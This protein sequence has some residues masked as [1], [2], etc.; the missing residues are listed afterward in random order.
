MISDLQIINHK[1][2]MRLS[3][4]LRIHPEE[5][6]AFVGGGG[7][8][9]AMFRLADELVTQ[10]K[11]VITTT[12]THLSIA[13]LPSSATKIG[14]GR[15]RTLAPLARG[16]VNADSLEAR[17]IL[18]VGDEVEAGKVVGVP[19]ALIGE[20]IAL[21]VVDAVIYEADGARML[22]FK[23]PAA[24]EPVLSDATTLLVPVIGAGVFGAPLDDAHVHRA[25]IV[26]R[27]AG[28]R[29]GDTVTPIIAA[30]VMAHAGGG[31]KGKPR[32]AH[33]IA[34]VNQVENDAQLDAARTLARLLLGYA[35]IDAVVIG[36]VQNAPNPIRET[37]RRV[38]AI[39]LAAG[40][41]TRMGGRVKQL[42]PWRG[43]TLVENAIAIAAQSSA[44][45]TVIVLGAHAEE[46]RATIR[47]GA[48]RVI[49]NR[50]W[51]TGHASSIRAGLRVLSPQIDAA[52]FVNADQPLL[53]SDVLDALAQRYRETDA[54]IVVPLYAGKRGSPV[55]F[56]RAHFEELANL[57]DEQGGRELLGKYRTK[58]EFVEFAEE[59]L[60]FDVDTAE[61]YESVRNQVF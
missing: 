19:P 30:R 26:A 37:H 35:E 3:Q 38:A 23:A 21:D 34:L 15:A 1:S 22:P 20:L 31:L 28:A 32:T 2:E 27:L 57:R 52:I 56:Q 6:V 53:T 46:I 47:S 45:E 36:A 44:S 8:T 14:C 40:A 18:I 55:L 7:K 60:G 50:E 5:V 58:I 17:H 11:R 24:H 49:V 42:L 13:Q 29:L 25:E 54:P 39:V 43:T 10:G 59:R 61:D 12:T 4:A 9:T 33:A 41:S 48:G 51:E 16:G